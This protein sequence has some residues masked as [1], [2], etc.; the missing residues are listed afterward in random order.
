MSRLLETVMD[1]C[2]QDTGDGNKKKK[3][4]N[5]KSSEIHLCPAQPRSSGKFPRV[6]KRM[7]G[8]ALRVSHK[9]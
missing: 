5:V 6:S 8:Q 2:F 1:R 4:T 3:K 7:L 9:Q